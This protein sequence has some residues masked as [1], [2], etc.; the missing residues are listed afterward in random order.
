MRL[1]TAA[2]Y[3]TNKLPASRHL[4]ASKSPD[5]YRGTVNKEISNGGWHEIWR[6]S[7]SKIEHDKIE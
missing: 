7:S 3:S 1:D 5:P 6:E 4:A 2:Y